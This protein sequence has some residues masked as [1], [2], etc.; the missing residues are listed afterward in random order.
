M[1]I[2]YGSKYRRDFIKSIVKANK[3]IEDAYILFSVIDELLIMDDDIDILPENK[4]RINADFVAIQ[5]HLQEIKITLA[6]DKHRRV[7]K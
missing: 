6:E 1:S 2:D 3:C 7:R 5:K 4:E